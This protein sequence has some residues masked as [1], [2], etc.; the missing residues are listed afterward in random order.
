MKS[1]LHYIGGLALGLAC[2]AGTARAE[3]VLSGS[4]AGYFQ[5][6]SSGNTVVTNV[7][8]GSW[9]SY[10]TGVPVRDSF[11]SG[12]TFSNTSFS[13]VK[14]GDS[15]G[16]GMLTYYNGITEIG[17]SSANA[18]FDFYLDLDT[19]DMAPLLLTTISFGIDA[20]VNTP[21]GTNPDIFTASFTQP[22]PILIG[23]T[24][25]TFTVND[26]PSV[27]N[28]QENMWL[29]LANITVSFFSP[30]PEPSTY[31][32]I[33]AAGLLGLV[34]YRRYRARRTAGAMAA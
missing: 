3:L 12:I 5:G 15:F 22:E 30:I 26:L 23:D 21:E 18:L 32:L 11:K 16:F 6:V 31:G 29:G 8:D 20:T 14:S 1:K 10:F 2:L 17:T 13:N 9:A 7:P 28:V 27:V 24:W 4:T 34:G 19:P 25:V 33:A